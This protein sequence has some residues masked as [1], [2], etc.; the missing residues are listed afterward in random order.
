MFNADK[1]TD[2]QLHRHDKANDLVSKFCERAKKKLVHTMKFGGK[3]KVCIYLSTFKLNDKAHG[4]VKNFEIIRY[5]RDA[6]RTGTS[7]NLRKR[8]CCL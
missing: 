1:W 8:C 7:P 4:T 6:E 2:G 5:K 3:D